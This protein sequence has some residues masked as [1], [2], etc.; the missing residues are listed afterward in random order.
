[1]WF[2]EKETDFLRSKHLKIHPWKN[3]NMISVENSKA[4]TYKL[5]VAESF[6]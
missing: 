2:S 4:D 3:T 5:S 1:M 6:C